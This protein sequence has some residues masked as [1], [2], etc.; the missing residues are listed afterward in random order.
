MEADRDAFGNVV[1]K[2]VKR[3]GKSQR[4]GDGILLANAYKL[5]NHLWASHPANRKEVLRCGL[6]ITQQRCRQFGRVGL[7]GVDFKGYG[8]RIYSL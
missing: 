3:S 5:V 4:V 2:K 1:K 6:S 8:R 7:T